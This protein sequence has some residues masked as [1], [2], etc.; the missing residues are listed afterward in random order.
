MT[1]AEY[2]EHFIASFQGQWKNMSDERRAEEWDAAM[3][4]REREGFPVF[5]NPWKNAPTPSDFEAGDYHDGPL[6]KCDW[7]RLTKD[8]K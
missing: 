6:D 5:P 3:E 4:Y 2:Q 1:R 8:S 7:T